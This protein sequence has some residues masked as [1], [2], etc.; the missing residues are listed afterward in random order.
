MSTTVFTRLGEREKNVLTR[1]G[2]RE[3]GVFTRLRP[4]NTSFQSNYQAFGKRQR[5]GRRNTPYLNT[6][7][8]SRPLPD[9]EEYVVSTS[10]DTLYMILWSTIKKSTFTANIPYPKSQYSVLVNTPY[11][12]KQYSVLVNTP[13]SKNQYSVLVN[14]PYLKNQYSVL[15]NMPYPK[16]GYAVLKA[17]EEN[18]GI[19]YLWSPRQVKMDDP[20]ITMEEYIR[21]EEEKARRRGKVYNW[22][23]ATYGKI[24]YDEV[25]HNLR[26]VEIKFPAIVFNVALTSEVA[27]SCE[28]TVSPFNNNQIDFRI[29]FDEFDDEDYTN[30][31]P[32]IAYNDALT[33]KLDFFEPTVSPQHIDEIDETSLS[34]CDDEGQNVI[35]FNDLFTFNIIYPEDLSDKDNDNDKIDIEHSLGDLSIEP[36][37]NVIKIDTQ[38]SNKLLEYD[39]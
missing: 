20:N 28:P 1:L 7:K 10:V 24:W 30:E 3:K 14:T 29:S 25:I 6:L 21:L 2:E 36:L 5:K 17:A 32:A 27:L 23:T 9:F 37:P 22:E 18:S 11:P 13:Y 8:H 12:K 33:S 16:I 35:Y 39:Q 31:F 38:G 26:S 34:E 4:V 19:F 15:V